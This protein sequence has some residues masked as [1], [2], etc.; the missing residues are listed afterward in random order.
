MRL[1]QLTAILCGIAALT[2]TGCS[3]PQTSTPDISPAPS[4]TATNSSA[5]AVANP[6]D[7][8]KLQADPCGA[9]TTAQLASYMGAVE[10]SEKKADSKVITCTWKP[11]DIYKPYISLSIY[12][13]FDS[14][15]MYETGNNLPFHQ[16]ISPIKGYPALNQSLGSDTIGTCQTDVAVADPGVAEVHAVDSTATYQYYNNMCVVSDALVQALIGNLKTEG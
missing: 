14:N 10:G 7:I 12:P 9:L 5:P 2:L 1:R 13:S 4:T 3:S 11:S 15:D 6:L 8:K 16:K